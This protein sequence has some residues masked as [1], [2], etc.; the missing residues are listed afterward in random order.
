MFRPGSKAIIIE[1][2]LMS[3]NETPRCPGGGAPC[4]SRLTGPPLSP[5]GI[6]ILGP[7]F[8]WVPYPIGR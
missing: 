7:L 8:R 2:R 1:G 3:W 5:G 6:S 4:A